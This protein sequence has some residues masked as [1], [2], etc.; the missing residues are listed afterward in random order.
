MDTPLTV[1]GGGPGGQS[2]D[3]SPPD[4]DTS[5]TELG[6]S[7]ESVQS[8]ADFDPFA[9]GTGSYVPVF[10]PH[11]KRL[12]GGAALSRSAS[13]TERSETGRPVGGGEV[14]DMEWDDPFVNDEYYVTSRNEPI[15]RHDESM[16]STG[17]PNDWYASDFLDDM[18]M[19]I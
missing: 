2:M 19:G 10:S 4:K 15:D 14:M 9:L 17:S 5:R 16:A 12:S 13:V 8:F 11:H 18:E 1:F 3:M 7:S 6:H